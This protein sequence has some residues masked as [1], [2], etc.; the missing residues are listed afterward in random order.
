M[1]ATI[2]VNGAE[3][4]LGVTTVAALV[5]QK[6]EQSNPRGIAV[7]INGAVVPRAAWADT[8]L[9]PGDRVEIVRVLQGG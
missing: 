1:D 6:A 9:E 5:A 7:A 8:A 3:E 4:P 2:H